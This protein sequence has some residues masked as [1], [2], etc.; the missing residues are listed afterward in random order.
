[1]G[2]TGTRGIERFI[3]MKTSFIA[4]YRDWISADAVV[5]KLLDWGF[6]HAEIEMKSCHFWLEAVYEG[7]SDV[8]KVFRLEGGEAVLQLEA[9]DRQSLKLAQ[10][11]L[12]GS[13]PLGVQIQ[14]PV[15]S[16]TWMSIPVTAAYI[17]TTTVLTVGGKL[18][19]P[20]SSQRAQRR[21]RASLCS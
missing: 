20:R 4:L 5:E 8:S 18:F 11:I 7:G 2:V 13:Y 14:N 17:Q 1:M 3:V 9:A 12:F 6:S 10:E 16:E 15:R 19:E 21:A